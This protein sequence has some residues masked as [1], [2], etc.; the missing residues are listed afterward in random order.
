MKKIRYRLRSVS[1]DVIITEVDRV[2]IF[3]RVLLPVS[4]GCKKAGSMKMEAGGSSSTFVTVCQLTR[5]NMPEDRS[6]KYDYGFGGSERSIAGQPV[7][8]IPDD[9]S[10]TCQKTRL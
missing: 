6:V 5:R 1:S 3:R 7:P 9:L 8:N 4:S 2:V 10:V